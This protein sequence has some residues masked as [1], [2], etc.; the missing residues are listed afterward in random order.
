MV[1]VGG[2]RIPP[3]LYFHYRLSSFFSESVQ[4]AEDLRRRE[5]KIL[6]DLL[7]IL[8]TDTPE[9]HLKHLSPDILLRYSINR[10][11]THIVLSPPVLRPQILQSSPV[12]RP[13]KRQ[14]MPHHVIQQIRVHAPHPQLMLPVPPESMGMKQVPLTK[15][16]LNTPV[17]SRLPAMMWLIFSESRRSNTAW[18]SNWLSAASSSTSMRSPRTRSS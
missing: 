17:L 10:T 14:R 7:H 8:A 15:L 13:T 9:K 2:V 18:D 11:Q 12:I 5:T 6:R 16:S 4:E 1:P 3:N